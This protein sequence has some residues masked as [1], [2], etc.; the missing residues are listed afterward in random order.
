[1][2]PTDPDATRRRRIFSNR[3]MSLFF[4]GGA[5]IAA[6]L[7]LYGK[8]GPSGNGAADECR[9]SAEIAAKMTP[10]IRGEVAAM[11]VAKTPKRL[12][13]ISFAS[14]AGQKSMIDFGG[15]TVLFNLWATWCVPCRAEMP[16]LDHLQKTLGGDQF[17]VLAL[18]TDAEGKA[19]QTLRKES[20]VTG[21]PTTFLVDAKGCVL[22]GMAGPAEWDSADAL[23]LLTS[24][25][26]AGRSK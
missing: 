11:Q 6:G 2:H 8:K 17:E 5:V 15:K 1:M 22:G 21:L 16:A 26:E 20:L 14:P 3:M 7:F 24:V 19:F 10:F 4:L 23:A 18:Y 12:P 25:I 9:G 13:P